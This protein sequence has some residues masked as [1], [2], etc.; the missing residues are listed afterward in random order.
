MLDALR[1]SVKTLPARIFI[2]VLVISFAIWGIGD[3]FSFRLNDRVAQVGDTEV[4]AQRF[5][6]ALAREQSRLTRQAR[7][8]VSYDAMRGAGIDQRIMAGLVRDAAFTEEL[9]GLGIS[10]PDEAVADA[11]RANDV[12]QGPGGQ[13]SNQAYQLFL[14]QQNL[15]PAEFE[16]LTR[17]LLTQQVLTETAEAGI[18]APPGASARIAAYQGERR[19]LTALTM[20]LEMADDPGEPDAGAL[21]EFY[22]GNEPLFTEP[23]RRFGQFIHVDAEMLAEALTPDEEA[24]RAAYEADIAAYTVE[25]TRTVD[26]IAIPDQVE[27][28]AAVGRLVG[29]TLTFEELGQEFGLDADALALGRIGRDDLPGVAADLIFAEA[30][31][32]IVGPVKLPA[33]YG[34]FRIKEIQP[35][36]TAPFEDVRD[37]IA[38]RMAAEAVRGV[39]PELAN[40]I[41]DLR[42]EGLSMPEIAQRMHGEEGGAAVIHGTFEG[43][44]RNATLT[45]GTDAEGI[46][47]NPVFIGETF[48]ALDA[49]ERDL[50]ETPAGGYLMIL[51]ERIEERALQPLDAV[52]DRAVAAWQDAQRLADLEAK[53][54]DIA[55]GLG[56]ENSIWKSGEALGTTVLPFGPFTRLTSPPAL[57]PLLVERAFEAEQDKGIFAP[58]DDGQGV[59]V[60][61]VISI[62]P[63]ETEMLAA[64]SAELDRVIEQSLRGDT[65]EYFARAIEGKHTTFV[66][67]EVVDQVFSL[68]GAV[69]A[70]S[71]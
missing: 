15:T 52:R 25:E 63:M 55:A 30:E 53:A 62:T 20:T 14:A 44:A 48:E 57:P 29:G 3:I 8:F 9:N 18:A 61:Q 22:D 12:F 2:A 23:E 6:D 69:N 37:Q 26:Q 60:A 71:Q 21:G 65:V 46:V 36:G 1:K 64:S 41:D 49:E 11:V 47:A 27:A 40:M 35:G 10:A 5:A 50:I 43:L 51:V 56:P 13:F 32:G 45:G 7:E 4:P 24:L 38:E 39:A 59:M 28:E 19:V 54:V 34:I 33:G 17:T 66:D 68:L 70:P 31:P 67:P 58:T 16:E 42:S